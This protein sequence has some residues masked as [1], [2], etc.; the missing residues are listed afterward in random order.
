MTIDAIIFPVED[1][2]VSV[3][4][5]FHSRFVDTTN[6]QIPTLVGNMVETSSLHGF[7][8]QLRDKYCVYM[9]H[10]F[11]IES[12]GVIINKILFS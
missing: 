11:V 5:F 9:A 10:P 3:Y 7:V 8:L 1:I 4:F 2:Y 6:W 12:R